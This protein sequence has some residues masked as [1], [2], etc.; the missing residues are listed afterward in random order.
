MKVIVYT[1]PDGGLSVCVPVEGWRLAF[2][3]TLVDGTVLPVGANTPGFKGKPPQPIDTILRK[4]P[5]TG[6]VAKWAETEDE[7]VARV[8]AKSVPADAINPK[9]VEAAAIPTDRIFRNAWEASGAAGVQV[10]MPKAREIHKTKLRELRA[11]KMAALDVDYMRADEA[12]DA[13]A[14]ADIAARKQALR[15]VMKDVRIESA[16]TPD[17]LKAVIPD[18]LK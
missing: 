14:K 15:D 9:F 17:K 10:N 5:V 6:A 11:P 18:I 16:T 3:I 7:F 13:A 4:W 12:G 1:R 2:W 8:A